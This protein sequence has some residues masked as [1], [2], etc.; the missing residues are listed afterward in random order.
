MTRV[1]WGTHLGDVNLGAFG[2]GHHHGLE[3]VVLRQGL[4]GGGPRFVTS[5]VQDPVDLVLEGLPQCVTGGGLQ[6]VVVG[7]LDHLKDNAKR[8]YVF[9]ENV[10]Q[11][12]R[13]SCRERV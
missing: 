7:L 1:P 4:L 8:K 6:L 3:V 9:F 11:I 10:V 5:V 12:G 13:A 2:A